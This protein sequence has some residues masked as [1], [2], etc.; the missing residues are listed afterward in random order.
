MFFHKFFPN[1]P[2]TK[3]TIFWT[4]TTPKPLYSSHPS[5]GFLKSYQTHNFFWLGCVFSLQIT[6]NLTNISHPNDS[7]YPNEH[8]YSDCD[9]LCNFWE[10]HRLQKNHS[11]EKHP[12]RNTQK[13]RYYPPEIRWRSKKPSV[14]WYTKP[15]KMRCFFAFKHKYKEKGI[16]KE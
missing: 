9:P 16:S 10:I 5:M 13:C 15:S 3:L 4:Q 2:L 7:V 8:P 12:P 1:F 14:V 11:G 6:K